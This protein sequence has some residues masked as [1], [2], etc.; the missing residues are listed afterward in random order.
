MINQR[1]E[2]PFQ[3]ILYMI[4]VWTNKGW[5]VG[6]IQSQQINISTNRPLPGSSYMFCSIKKS[7]TTQHQKQRSKIFFVFLILQKNIKKQLKNSTKELLK[8]LIMM[9]EL[10]F[11]CKKKILARLK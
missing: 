2:N 3:E 6:S 4:D 1:Q 7:R 8:K 11:P 10:S 5:N 9:M